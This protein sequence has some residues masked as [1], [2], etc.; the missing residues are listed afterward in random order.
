MI[1]LLIWKIFS[2]SKGLV[3]F[4]TILYNCTLY[5]CTLWCTTVLYLGESSPQW[6][7]PSSAPAPGAWP[8]STVRPSPSWPLCPGTLPLSLSLS[9]WS[10]C[11]G[12]FYSL[13]CCIPMYGH[14]AQVHCTDFGFQPPKSGF[15]TLKLVQVRTIRDL[16]SPQCQPN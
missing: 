16:S 11:P 9:L 4:Y 13:L 1:N 14:F 10:L 5:N 8:D 7:P 12:T 2:A 6:T 15:N 3:L